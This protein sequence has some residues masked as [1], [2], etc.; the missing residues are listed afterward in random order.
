MRNALGF[1]LA[2][3]CAFA[4]QPWMRRAE[5]WSEMD[6]QRV[7]RE[8]PWAKTVGVGGRKAIV[9]WESSRPIRQARDKLRIALSLDETYYVISVDGLA[10]TDQTTAKLRYCGQEPASQFRVEIAEQIAKYPI[11]LF[12]F[13]RTPI[14]H[15]PTVF[16][17]PLGIT[18]N[19]KK[20]EFEAQLGTVVIRS[21]FPVTDM[22]FEGDLAL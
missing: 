14:E 8:S 10:L 19:P 17:L 18:V 12:L 11:V 13:P 16:R 22:I 7:L 4:A 9:R 2:I 20:F 15:M 1:L 6:A 5:D 3:G 21:K